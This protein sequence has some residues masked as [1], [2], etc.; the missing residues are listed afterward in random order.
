[1]A[2]NVFAPNPCGWVRLA[3]GELRAPTRGLAGAC[4]VCAATPTRRRKC[5]PVPRRPTTA[6]ATMAL[7]RRCSQT[8][9]ARPAGVSTRGDGP[10]LPKCRGLSV[11]R[12][13]GVRRLDW[14]GRDVEN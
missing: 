5:G 11:P 7:H 12:D 8:E 14:I 10:T 3:G 13:A 2:A 4:M 1:L 9:L 6:G